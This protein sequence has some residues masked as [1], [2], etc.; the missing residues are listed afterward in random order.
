MKS[1]DVLPIEDP[2]TGLN[3]FLNGDADLMMD[4]GMI[5]NTVV[6]QLQGEPWFHT[7][8]F[9][10]TYFTRFNCEEGPFTDPRVRRAFAMAIDKKRITEKITKLGEVVA[11]G[12]VPPGAGQG[13]E[14]PAGLPYDV[15][16]ARALMKDA[17]YEG[18]AGFPLIRYLYINKPIETHIAV[19]LQNMWK[20][21]LGVTVALHKQE[22]KVW[23]TSMKQLDYDLCRSS[24][25]GD[26]NDPN[27][28]LDMFVTGGGNNRT[29][30]SSA[31]YDGY[32]AAAA[33]EPDPAKRNAIFQK[34]ESLLVAEEAAVLPIYYY[35]GVQFYHPEKLG[36]VQTNLLD[37][38]PFRAMFWK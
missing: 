4:K 25:V 35:V 15:E 1:V 26:Y 34:A 20:D 33:A 38:H 37:E 16:K 19:E 2:N 23:L 12:F 24:W 13:Y 17:G 31:D 7:A 5:P 8:P 3:F 18:G 28:F 32:I 27:T 30:W 22:Q 14:S 9:L 21:A 11:D 10:G 29:G 36:G 6:D